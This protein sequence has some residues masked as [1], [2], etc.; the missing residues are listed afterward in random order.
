MPKNNTFITAL[1]VGTGKVTALIATV[2]PEGRVQFVGKGVARNVDGMIGGN[3]V[4]MEAT[5]RAINEA[6]TEADKIGDTHTKSV[7]LGLSGDHITSINSH[8]VVTVRGREVTQSDI[9]RVIEQAKNVNLPADRRIVGLEIGEFVVD[10]Q[11]GIKNPRGM[12]GRRLEVKIHII[13]ASITMIQNLVRSVTDAGLQVDD[14]IVNGLA[15]A[16]AVLQDDEKQL[17]VALV[18]IGDGTADIVVYRQGRLA[19]TAVVPMGGR[20]ITRDISIALRMPPAEAERVKCRYGSAVTASVGP[21]EEIEVTCIGDEEKKLIK[22]QLVAQVISPRVEEILTHVRRRMSE[23]AKDSFISSGIVI[24]GGT[25]NLRYLK[26][27][28]EE[29]LG[30]PTRIG[31]PIVAD[32]GMG[33]AELLRDPSFA[34][35]VGAV[36]YSLRHDKVKETSESFWGRMGRWIEKFFQ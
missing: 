1:D 22:A 8:G 7:L 21:E 30:L 27:L 10:D 32:D 2:S 20:F 13:T 29:V 4:N 14:I 5:T 12:A 11:N 33:F 16:E 31:R 36:Y 9:D 28:A 35:A 26:N 6:V 23:D 19:Y 15:A 3:V 34:A 24:T 25:A 18:D 17:G